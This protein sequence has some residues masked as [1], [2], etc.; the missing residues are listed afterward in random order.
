MF[1]ADAAHELRTPLAV[2]ISETQTTLARPRSVDEYLQ[3]VEG[4][5]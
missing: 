4:L 2:M 3:T 1:T 5:P